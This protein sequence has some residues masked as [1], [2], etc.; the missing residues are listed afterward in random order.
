M[1]GLIG[2]RVAGRYEL[3]EILGAGSFGA[4]FK[5]RDLKAGPEGPFHYAVKVLLKPEPD[6]INEILL[7]REITLHERVTGHE[8][9]VGLHDVF[10][11]DTRI[12][13]L[14]DLAEAGTLKDVITDDKFYTVKDRDEKV[15][16]LFLSVLDGLEHCHK[17]GVFHRDLKPENILCSSDG[18]S[19]RIA[20]F[21]LATD[22]E[23]SDTFGCGTEAYISPEAVDPQNPCPT[24]SPYCQDLW[25]LGVILVNIIARR[26]PWNAATINDLCFKAYLQRP[27]YLYKVLDISNEVAELLIKIFEPNPLNRL[28]IP[29]IRQRVKAIGRFF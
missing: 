11:D 22:E 13:L 28:H 4:V 21:G 24:T 16:S 18:K 5:A 10:R 7:E 14:L 25:A 29:Q 3:T 8:N 6:S 12:F 20:D 19:T 23:L 2:Y 9:V 17:L 27:D 15:K 26:N 1:E